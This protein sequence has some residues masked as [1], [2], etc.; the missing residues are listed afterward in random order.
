MRMPRFVGIIQIVSR[1]DSKVGNEFDY[2]G[3]PARIVHPPPTAD[4]E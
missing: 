4:A 1:F 3:Q 2:T